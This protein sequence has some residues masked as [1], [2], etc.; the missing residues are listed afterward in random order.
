MK[1]LGINHDMYITSAALII[2]GKIIAA[3]PE[4]R[5][6][7]SKMTR[8]FPTNA[9]NFCLKQAN[10]KLD[11]VDYIANSYNPAVHM[12]KFHSIFSKHR[13][14]RGDYYYSVPDFLL[15][16]DRKINEDS[17]YSSQK[18]RL[19]K[20]EL[21][22]YYINH[23]LCHAAN[24]FNISPFKKSSIL[25]ADG[26]GEDDTA[27][28]LIGD[29]NKIKLLK[30]LKIPHSL[31]S[32]YSTFTEYLGYKP[33]HDEWKVMALSSFGSKNNRYYKIIKNM[34][35]L[36]SDGSFELNQN[37][38]KQF[39]HTLPNMFT[40]N[41]VSLLGKPKKKN[42]KMNKKDYEIAAAM[43]QVFED[44]GSHMLKHLY[45][46][47]NNKNL[48]L[49]GGSFMNSVFNGKIKKLSPFSKVWLS[50]CPDDSGLSIGA[51]LYLYNNI[52]GNKKRY[53]LKHNFLGP[54]Y[55][56]DKIKEDLKKYKVN[57]A[58]KKNITDVVSQEIAEGKLIGW[59]QG[60]MEFGQRALGN[61][62][63][64]ADP[65]KISSKARVNQAV[66]YRE[67]FRP[68]APA[69]LDTFAHEF[70][71]LEKNEKIPFMEKVVLTKKNKRHII[72]SVVHKDFTARVQTVDKKTNSL[73]Y[74]LIKKFYEKTGV[75]VLLNTSFNINGEPIVCNPTDAI[76]TF[77]SCG[78]DILV[79]GNYIIYK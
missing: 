56:S 27:N 16:I 67:N 46:K 31:G 3:C 2:D 20:K 68:F 10:I 44:T 57:F 33:E 64:L 11:Q 35:D 70:F 29:K 18:I 13:R 61:R 58:Y 63:I 36:K 53:E 4:E 41:F 43:Q 76:R 73:F 59:F 74:D 7:R 65:R 66:K 38:F 40:E 24:G 9:V 22:I 71:D 48:V 23:H 47:T 14:F 26:A 1:I 15:N 78:L 72:P 6:T 50:S 54:S 62:S 69:V 52:L 79:I 42:D 19:G 12:K 39:N 5:L 37:Y 21:N 17:D 8:A 51:A 25:T 55:K 28:F 49:S 60:K 77:Y 32:F 30:K 34:V 45:K 75:P